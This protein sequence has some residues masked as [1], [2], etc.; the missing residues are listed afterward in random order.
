MTN[1]A[2]HMRLWSVVSVSCMVCFD[3]SDQELAQ[4][5][6]TELQPWFGNQ[7]ED[8]SHILKLIKYV[9]CF[10]LAVLKDDLTIADNEN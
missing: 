6:K 9:D 1:V 8:W 7:V 5:I 2:Q 4:K 10:Q 3:Y